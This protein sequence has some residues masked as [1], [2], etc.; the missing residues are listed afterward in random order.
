MGHIWVVILASSA[1]YYALLANKLSKRCD[2]LMTQLQRLR[3][4]HAISEGEYQD[5]IQGMR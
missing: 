5:I 3:N 2:Y 4:E 1:L